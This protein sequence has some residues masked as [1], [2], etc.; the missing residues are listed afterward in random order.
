[1]DRADRHEYG[2]HGPG[3]DSNEP[4]PMPASRAAPGVAAKSTRNIRSI[5]HMPGGDIEC[6]ADRIRVGVDHCER[7]TEFDTDSRR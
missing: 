4:D 2:Q 3:G 5:R 6:C 7:A 1:V